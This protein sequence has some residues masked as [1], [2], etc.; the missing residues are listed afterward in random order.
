MCWFW[1]TIYGESNFRCEIRRALY[2][3]PRLLIVPQQ[4]A[5]FSYKL[6]P[7]SCVIP[8]VLWRRQLIQE[9]K[10]VAK[11]KP[12]WDVWLRSANLLPKLKPCSESGWQPTLMHRESFHIRE[13]HLIGNPPCCMHVI[14]ILALKY[15]S[16]VLSGSLRSTSAQNLENQH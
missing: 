3:C 13:F 6:Y 10:G 14:C 16:T 5:S 1:Y 11:F 9:L 12:F 7:S 4:G 2:N 15:N 8:K